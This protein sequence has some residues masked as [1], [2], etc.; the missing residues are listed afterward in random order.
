MPMWT[1][2]PNSMLLLK[3]TLPVGK[4]Q[5]PLTTNNTHLAA[6]TTTT[7][8]TL[9]TRWW[10]GAKTS[11]LSAS[12]SSTQRMSSHTSKMLMT[13]KSSKTMIFQYNKM[14]CT[15]RGSADRS[16]P[17]S[18]MQPLRKERSSLVLVQWLLLSGLLGK[19]RFNQ[20]LG[21]LLLC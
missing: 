13:K 18:L 16:L 15:S 3:S 12:V 9:W 20:L 6:T 4:R 2:S 11:R 17:R 5:L 19:M 21:K 14:S 8:I 10:I 7:W 1:E